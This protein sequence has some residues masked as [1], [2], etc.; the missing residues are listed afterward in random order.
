MTHAHFVA[1]MVRHTAQHISTHV[2]AHASGTVAHT[3]AAPPAMH[4]A[5]GQLAPSKPDGLPQLQL[6]RRPVSFRKIVGLR[7]QR[8]MEMSAAYGKLR[9][10]APASREIC[11]GLVGRHAQPGCCQLASPALSLLPP[12][13][14][15]PPAPRPWHA[16]SA[17]FFTAAAAAS[18]AAATG[19]VGG[20]GASAAGSTA[21]YEFDVE[22]PEWH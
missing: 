10:G 6:P 15:S 8:S 19:W 7:S 18:T 22:V 11:Q 9:K 12:M 1:H 3:V 16:G 2:V 17:S 20:A 4:P 5:N 21:G 13:R 14:I